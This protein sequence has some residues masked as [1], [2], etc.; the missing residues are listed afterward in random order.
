M[1]AQWTDEETALF[2]RTYPVKTSSQMKELFPQYT[3]QQMLTKAS[4]LGIVKGKE[5]ATESRRQNLN[6]KDQDEIW[7]DKEKKVLLDVYP[8]RGFQGVYEALDGKRTISGINRMVRRLKVTRIQKNLV[9]EQSEF[10]V[11]KSDRSIEITYK[12]W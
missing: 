3:W 4:G 8:I 2:K 12:G 6:H 9:W 7:S 1:R 10:S 11:N 5:V